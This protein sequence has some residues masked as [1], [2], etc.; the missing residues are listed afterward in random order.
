LCGSLVIS[1]FYSVKLILR[2]FFI[3]NKHIALFPATVK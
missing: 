2:L 1:I 3:I